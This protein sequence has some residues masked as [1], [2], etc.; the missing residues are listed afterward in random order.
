MSC[1]IYPI[2]IIFMFIL[3]VYIAVKYDIRPDTG[4]TDEWSNCEIGIVAVVSIL[5]GIVWP[6][7]L[8]CILAFVFVKFVVKSS[9]NKGE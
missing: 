2:C 4:F 6:V 1:P 8:A 7:S 5:S 3:T 9:S